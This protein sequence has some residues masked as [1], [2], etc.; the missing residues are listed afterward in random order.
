MK[1]PFAFAKLP[2][3]SIAVP[4]VFFMLTS[5]GGARPVSPDYAPALLVA[6]GQGAGALTIHFMQP[7]TSDPT[8]K[9]EIYVPSGLSPSLAAPAGSTIGVVVAT[10]SAA[11]YGGTVLKLA[12]HVVVRGAS[13]TFSSGSG[14]QLPLATAAMSCTGSE[15]HTAFWV[16]RLGAKG[17]LQE[18]P[19][20]VDAVPSGDPLTSAA[21]T[22]QA[23]LPPPDV[24]QGTPGRSPFGINVFDARLT[25]RKVFPAATGEFLWRM[26]GTPFVPGTGTPNLSAAVESQSPQRI[27]PSIR[28]VATGI[29]GKARARVSG[30]VTEG[31]KPVAGAIVKII[32]ETVLA[33]VRTDRSGHFRATVGVATPKDVLYATAVEPRRNL[34]ATACVPTFASAGIPC[35]SAIVSGF[36]VTSRKVV[37]RT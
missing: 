17:L 27:P 1:R 14:I 2:A 28:F 23:C 24:P 4:M 15:A 21:A 26:V 10:A 6:S 12:G 32:C 11:D 18:V 33:T 25:F 29:K 9:I 35:I 19:A 31:G 5:A 13:D 3:A 8:A 7:K 30:T 36:T 22:I 20:F 16:L 34:G 37:V